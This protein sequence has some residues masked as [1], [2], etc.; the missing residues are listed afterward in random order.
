MMCHFPDELES[1]SLCWP[2]GSHPGVALSLFL[3]GS[4]W[5]AV[6]G[7]KLTGSCQVFYANPR[8]VQALA[9]RDLPLVME[10]CI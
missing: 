3:G 8:R 6:S 2:G 4:L 1:E 5:E 7:Q 10:K 9:C